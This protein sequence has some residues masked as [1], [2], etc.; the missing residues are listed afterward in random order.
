[1]RLWLFSSLAMT[2]CAAMIASA[3]NDAVTVPAPDRL[4]ASS[5]VGVLAT[6]CGQGCTPEMSAIATN[7]VRDLFVKACYDV[8]D[9]PELAPPAAG[10]GID[11]GGGK[12]VTLGLGLTGIQV[13][14]PGEAV[15][16]GFTLPPGV[17]EAIIADA[18]KRR[19]I[20]SL[21]SSALTVSD[22][23]PNSGFR[24]GTIGIQLVDLE[25]RSTLLRAS[26]QGAFGD[27]SQ[28][29]QALSGLFLVL[30]SGMAQK[31]SLCP[32]AP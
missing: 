1:M 32:A 10:I 23:D 8:I 9:A 28:A 27:P 15:A 26:F 24:R 7:K 20:Q 16:L 13:G 12:R 5:K 25:G 22:P 21:A 6:A 18:A 11:A 2:G 3:G 14:A 31:A 4:A 29:D 17:N 30:E 19:G